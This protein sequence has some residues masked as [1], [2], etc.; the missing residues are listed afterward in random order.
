ARALRAAC[1]QACVTQALSSGSLAYLRIADELTPRGAPERPDLLLLSDFFCAAR[2]NDWE[3]P[4]AAG[5]TLDLALRLAFSVS[6]ERTAARFW[7][8]FATAPCDSLALSPE[9]LRDL[10]RKC[11]ASVIHGRVQAGRDVAW[12]ELLPHQ[13]SALLEL[14]PLPEQAALFCPIAA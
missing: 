12:P 3:E 5:A 4:S 10:W 1:A 6:A 8:R 9:V 14:G 11:P 13:F 2:P 7:D